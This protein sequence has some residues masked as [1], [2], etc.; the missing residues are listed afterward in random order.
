MKDHCDH[1]KFVEI[2]YND[3][4]RD[5]RPQAEQLSSFLDGLDIEEIVAVTDPSLYRNRA[6]D[7]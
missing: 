5:P 1:F 6:Q 3:M 7:S 2:N 4:L